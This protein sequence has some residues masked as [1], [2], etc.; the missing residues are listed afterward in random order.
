MKSLPILN[1]IHTFGMVIT[2]VV[3]A[4]IGFRYTDKAVAGP[5]DN[6]HGWLWSDMPTT[7]DQAINPNNMPGGR[8]FGWISMNGADAGAGGNYGVN[9]DMTD[10]WL[11]GYAWSEMG[12]YLWFDAPGPRPAHSLEPGNVTAPAQVDYNCLNSTQVVCP[13]TGWA[14]FIAG[15]GVSTGGWDGWVSMQGGTSQNNDYGV[16]YNKTTKQFSGNAWGDINAGWINFDNAYISTTPPPTNLTCITATGAT[17][18]YLSTDPTP[19]ACLFSVCYDALGTQFTYPLGDPM[20]SQC[21]ST[22]PPDDPLVDLCPDNAN[23]LLPGMQSSLPVFYQGTWWEDPNND[24]KCTAI[25]NP[26]PGCTDPNATN[27]NPLANVND[28][29]C[30]YGPVGPGGSGSP[31]KPIYKEN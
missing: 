28:G 5:S 8:G 3:I 11:T 14:R 7:S 19:A 22:E 31:V 21:V 29:T 12:G 16:F 9:L 26:I 24:G 1:K 6:V 15:S 30:S 23:P 17:I 27:Y 10:G 18:T 13:V 2:L 20:P 25:R 4:V